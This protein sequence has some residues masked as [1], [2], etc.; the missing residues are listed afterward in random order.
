MKIIAIIDEDANIL[1]QLMGIETMILQA[2][3]LPSFRR[4]FDPL[5]Q[6]PE[7]GIIIINEQYLI[8]FKEYFRE[9]KT[10]KYPL[11]VEVPNF[12]KVLSQ[13]YYENF[14]RNLLNLDFL[15]QT[16]AQ[17]EVQK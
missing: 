10:R 9:I 14:I 3:D 12:E 11:I 7:I 15:A 8:R 16:E 5:L 6:K 17:T 2:D 13:N 4:D 1:F